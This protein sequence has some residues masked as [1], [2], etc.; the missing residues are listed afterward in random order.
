[1][2]MIV[3]MRLMTASASLLLLAPLAA[4]GSDTADSA[5]ADGLS[6]IASFYPLQYVTERV[7]GDLVDVQSL[8]TSG[9]DPHDAEL[10]VA[11][12]AEIMD[13][14]L[15]V[16]LSAFQ[17]AVDDAI[18]QADGV[19]VVDAADAAE[20]IPLSEDATADHGHEGDEYAEE[21]GEH[22]E[23]EGEALDPHFWL[24]PTRLAAVAADVADALAEEDPD[25]ADQYAANLADLERDLEALDEEITT[26]L[27]DC[28]LD[29]V[30]VSHNAFQYWAVRYDLHMHPIAGL[31]PESEPSPEHVAELQDL[32]REEGITTVFSETLA[33]PKMAETLSA[34]LG[35]TTDVLDPVEGL[36]DETA[37]EDYLSLMRQNLAALQQ[38]NDC[39]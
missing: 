28:A 18:T 32:I 23:E 13:A 24:D 12:T 1:M 27:Q 25:N 2:R 4:C 35:L 7:A 6:V 22:A 30:V 37:D 33:S 34:D 26:G 29:S 9:T 16:H 19:P 38:A 15:V 8:S 20:L 39:R 17:P 31:S 11:Q 21:E 3:I 14:D 10:S 36:S 5:D